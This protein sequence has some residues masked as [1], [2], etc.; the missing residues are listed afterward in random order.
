MNDWIHEYISFLLSFS[1][2]T[3]L[4]IESSCTQTFEFLFMSVF[5]QWAQ[6]LTATK[7]AA[8]FIYHLSAHL[9]TSYHRKHKFFT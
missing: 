5:V 4:Q 8:L 6:Q 9:I 7:E 1:Q 3:R 2:E